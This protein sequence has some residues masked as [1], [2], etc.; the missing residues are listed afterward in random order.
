MSAS[1]EWTG[2][3]VEG[4]EGEGAREGEERGQSGGRTRERERGRGE[5]RDQCVGCVEWRVYKWMVCMRGY[6]K[7][8]LNRGI[9]TC[10]L[11]TSC[12]VMAIYFSCH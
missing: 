3:E 2:G 11:H 9:R 12:I 4:R 6:S 1:R 7:L 10:Y 8:Q 5:E